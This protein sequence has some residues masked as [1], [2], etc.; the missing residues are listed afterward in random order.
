MALEFYEA[1]KTHAK[2]FPDKPAIIDGD[3]SLS[4]AG[5]LE[6]TEKFAG[7]LDTLGLGPKS[8]IAILAYLDGILDVLFFAIM[9][10]QISLFLGKAIDF[11]FNFIAS[12]SVY[13]N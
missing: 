10:T 5:L 3:T 1:L 12:I 2:N 13:N 11:D 4:Y 7:A 9:V 8:K 6:Q